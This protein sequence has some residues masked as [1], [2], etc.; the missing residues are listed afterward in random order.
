MRGKRMSQRMRGH[1]PLYSRTSY[2][3]IKPATHIRGRQ[4][5]S[6][7]RDEEGRLRFL[8]ERGPATFEVARD[9]PPGRLAGGDDPRLRALPE[10]AQVLGVGVGV[11]HVQVHDL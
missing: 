4:S 10:H 5:L 8:L 2:P 6:G 7:L 1:S 9:R 11:C 3:T